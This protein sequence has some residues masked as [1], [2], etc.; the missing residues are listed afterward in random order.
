MANFALTE[1]SDGT[2]YLKCRCGEIGQ[3]C[4]YKGE[5][6]FA[7]AGLTLMRQAKLEA[8]G[9]CWDQHRILACFVIFDISRNTEEIPVPV[10]LKP[11]LVTTGPKQAQEAIAVPAKKV[12]A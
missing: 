12:G 2:I 6:T 10:A 4:D 5:V 9:H 8:Y 11:F 3:P 7:A 1:R